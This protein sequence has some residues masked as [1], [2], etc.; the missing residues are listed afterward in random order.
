MV[1][2]V[3]LWCSSATFLKK[4]AL[5]LRLRGCNR[6]A[7]QFQGQQG[8]SE[9]LLALFR[10]DLGRGYEGVAFLRVSSLFLCI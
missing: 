1:G 4:V 6:G 3:L 8:I 9:H 2:D 7:S 10:F 5:V